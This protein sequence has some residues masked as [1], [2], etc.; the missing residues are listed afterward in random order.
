MGS[1]VE[2]APQTCGVRINAALVTNAEAPQHTQSYPLKASWLPPNIS[3]LSGL[4]ACHDLFPQAD[5][6]SSE[7]QKDTDHAEKKKHNKKTKGPRSQ[8]IKKT[9][10]TQ[11]K[12]T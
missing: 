10:I 2:S 12:T 4:R 1:L 5:G 11:Q 9:Q 7:E 6:R 3:L 8:P